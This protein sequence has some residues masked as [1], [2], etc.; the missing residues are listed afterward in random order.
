MS[1][2]SIKPLAD[3]VVIEPLA[4]EEKPQEELLFPILQKKN[5][6]VEL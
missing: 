3:R 5:H 4:A 2:V 1:K 6:S